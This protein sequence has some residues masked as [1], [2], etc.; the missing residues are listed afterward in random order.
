MSELALE[1]EIDIEE[2]NSDESPVDSDNDGGELGE[3][4]TEGEEDIMT[5]EDMTE[6]EMEEAYSGCAASYGQH[7]PE[8]RANGGGAEDDG[9][10]GA[11]EWGAD[12]GYVQT[13]S[14]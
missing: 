13:W 3:L 2:N 7:E 14:Q 5:V 12:S 4:E 10:G 8:A 9:A 6:S 11:C 1:I